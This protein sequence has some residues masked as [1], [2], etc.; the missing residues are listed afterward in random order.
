MV[1]TGLLKGWPG[2]MG[3]KFNQPHRQKWRHRQRQRGTDHHRYR[4]VE[5]NRPHVG[6]HHPR[7]KGHRQKGQNH[8]NRG[9][10]DRTTQL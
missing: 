10:N 3:F 7:D 2:S 9:Q 1:G 5:R 6:P 8:R 4:H